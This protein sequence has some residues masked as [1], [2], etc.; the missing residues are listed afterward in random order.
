M[1]VNNAR[2]PYQPGVGA[3]ESRAGAAAVPFMAQTSS[4]S[5]LGPLGLQAAPEGVL[6]AAVEAAV[7]TDEGD[8]D[9][10]VT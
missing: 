7:G 4:T 1:R 6:M 8:V 2:H 5:S 9:G 10:V 3:E